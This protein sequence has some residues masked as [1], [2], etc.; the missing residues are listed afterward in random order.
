MVNLFNNVTEMEN[1]PEQDGKQCS[2]NYCVIIGQSFT[3]L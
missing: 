3:E 1:I 2:Y